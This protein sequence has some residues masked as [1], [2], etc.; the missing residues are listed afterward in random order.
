MF[1]V[2]II[3][4]KMVLRYVKSIKIVFL[5]DD[6][7][8]LARIHLVL[9]I[10]L[11]VPCWIYFGLDC[12]WFYIILTES[13]FSMLLIHDFLVS[14]M[15]SIK[16]TCFPN[17]QFYFSLHYAQIRDYIHVMDLADGHIAALQ[18]LFTTENLGDCSYYLECH[19]SEWIY[20]VRNIC[21]NFLWHLGVLN[22]ISCLRMCCL[23]PGNWTRYVGASNGCWLREG[24]WQGDCAIPSY[25][26]LFL[27]LNQFFI[28]ELF[29]NCLYPR[30]SPSNYAQG[31]REMLLLFMLQQRKLKGNSGGSK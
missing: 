4:P 22:R 13:S 29:L 12:I 27:F 6:W 10:Q 15:Q 20:H 2:M 19:V 31:G 23:Q 28:V 8:G 14:L 9:D 26:Y 21:G 24:F 17:Y 1:M 25:H 30:K 16:S 5:Q 11:L 3:P 7:V 18:K